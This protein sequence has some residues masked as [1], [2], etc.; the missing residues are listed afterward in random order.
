MKTSELEIVYKWAK[1]LTAKQ[2][3]EV[4]IEL[5][6]F[7]E[8]SEMVSINDVAPYWSNS[9]EPLVDGQKIWNDE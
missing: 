4:L 2:M 7:A 6:E 5:I 9:G 3:R 1:K 8:T